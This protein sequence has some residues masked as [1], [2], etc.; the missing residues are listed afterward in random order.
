MLNIIIIVRNVVGRNPHCSFP[1]DTH[2]HHTPPHCYCAYCYK[3]SSRTNK[4]TWCQLL[5]INSIISTSFSIKVYEI[6]AQKRTEKID[7]ESIQFS[8]AYHS[9]FASAPIAFRRG[10]IPGFISKKNK[11]ADRQRFGEM[12][13]QW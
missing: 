5:S 9:K 11:K 10:D 13:K 2:H 7:R 8:T 6:Q 4:I 12:G 1:D 3:I